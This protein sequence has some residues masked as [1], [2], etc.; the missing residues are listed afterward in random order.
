MNKPSPGPLSD[1]VRSCPVASEKS[2]DKT[3]EEEIRTPLTPLTGGEDS[4]VERVRRGSRR[5]RDLD[6]LYDLP[7][8]PADTAQSDAANESWQEAVDVVRS[9]ISPA[10][11]E[12]WIEPVQ[13]LGESEGRIVVAADRRVAFWLQ[14]RFVPMLTE[15]LC[16]DLFVCEK[17]S[18]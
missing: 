13:V 14:K 9:L 12:T 7:P 17:G 11:F 10:R 2:I 16:L 1:L 6:A 5:R 4:R 8:I 18:S 15:L 3:R